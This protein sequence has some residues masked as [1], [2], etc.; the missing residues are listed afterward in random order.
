MGSCGSLGSQFQQ[1]DETT[2]R[3][4][5]KTEKEKTKRKNEKEK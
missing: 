1:P 3:L 5:Y 4:K 2:S